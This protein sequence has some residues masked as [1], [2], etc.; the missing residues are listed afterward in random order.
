[1]D[2][3]DLARPYYAEAEFG[4]TS[5]YLLNENVRFFLIY[6]INKQFYY[7]QQQEYGIIVN[8]V[9]AI[10]INSLCLRVRNQKV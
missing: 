6:L 8:M 3:F 2:I 7:A 10:N 4:L 5:S 1:L 9:G